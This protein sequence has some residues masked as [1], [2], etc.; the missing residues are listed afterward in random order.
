MSL[1]LIVPAFVVM[2]LM[3]PQVSHAADAASPYKNV[4]H[5]TDAGNDTGDSQVDKLNETQLDKNY[6]GPTYF[7]GQPPVPQTAPIKIN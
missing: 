6:K 1:K 3:A 5:R 4:D 7:Q 2:A